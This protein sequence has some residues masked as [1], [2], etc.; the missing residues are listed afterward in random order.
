MA[1]VHGGRRDNWYNRQC[2]VGT[3]TKRRSDEVAL[4]SQAAN[5]AEGAADWWRERI[6]GIVRRKD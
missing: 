4:P 6:K 3:Q 1:S 2:V 5:A